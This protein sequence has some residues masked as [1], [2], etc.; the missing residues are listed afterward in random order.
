[1]KQVA[2]IETKKVNIE[3]EVDT[4][5][6]DSSKNKYQSWIDMARAVDAWRIFP[7]LFLTVYIVLLYKVV[8]WYMN[9]GAPTMEQSGLVS[10][11]VGAGAAWFGLYTSSA[12]KEHADPNPN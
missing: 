8:I 3:L 4:N 11:V 1:M 6:V 5:V 2:E 7:R 10:I 12:A 9:L